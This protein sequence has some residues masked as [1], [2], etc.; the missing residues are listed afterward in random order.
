MKC[1]DGIWLEPLDAWL[2][3]R[4]SG[5]ESA[6]GSVAEAASK[7]QAHALLTRAKETVETVLRSMDTPSPVSSF[8]GAEAGPGANCRRRNRNPEEAPR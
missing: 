4:R 8:G 1:V 7:E 2:L 5:T 3:I 6:I